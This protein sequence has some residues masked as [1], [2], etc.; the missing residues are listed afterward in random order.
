MKIKLPFNY[1]LF[2]A[3]TLVGLS[4]CKESD[5]PESESSENDEI[6]LRGIVEMNVA[7]RANTSIYDIN[8]EFYPNSDF[9]IVVS[10]DNR[11]GEPVVKKSRYVIPSG[12]KG[13]LMPKSGNPAISWISR[14]SEHDIWSW[15]VPWEP[16]APITGGSFPIEFRSTDIREAIYTSSNMQF[17]EG[18]FANGKLM[19]QC[20][21]AVLGGKRYVDQGQFVQL[22]FRHLCSLILLGE[23]V[24]VDNSTQT[25]SSTLRG[26][27]TIYGLPQR[28]TFHTTP[29][30]PEGKAMQPYIEMPE[31]FDY[32]PASQVT[33]AITNSS[34]SFKND[35]GFNVYNS[36]KSSST[37]FYDEWYIC[38]EVDLSRLS[39]IIEIFEYNSTT[40]EWQMSQKYGENGAFY[41]DFSSIQISRTPGSNYDADD[42]TDDSTVLHA[43]EFIQLAFNLSTKGNPS[44]RGVIVDWANT[45]SD[46]G[47]SKY[48]EDGIYSIVEAQDFSNMM[49]SGDPDKI[50]E[51]FGAYGSGERTGDD[52]D[53]PNYEDDLGIFRLYEDI[54]YFGTGQATTTGSTAKMSNLY[55]GDD[56][57]LDG[58]GHMVNCSTSSMKIGHVR[59]IYFRFYI[60]SY[61]TSTGAYSYTENI[62]YI[63]KSGQIY[64]VNPATY[65]MTDTGRNLNDYDKNPLT[66][67]LS[68]GTVS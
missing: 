19:R 16:E 61:S 40:K 15:T 38:P 60:S 26:N 48:D 13:I 29:F 1:I 66:L 63:D 35:S 23:F 41:G 46:R 24:I 56:Y 36:F 11:E 53:D 42:G 54:G 67:S 34:R 49:N 17:I 52:P 25:S 43:G 22:Q 28:A 5:M 57:I 50:D 30:T 39:F 58:M 51:Y 32:S 14:Y 21:G 65:E 4:A 18:S 10:G 44:I 3:F 37:S 59:D 12:A 55:V 6:L 20:V 7:T 8:A 33:F 47:A 31:D 64:K 62:I 2:I 27:M 9:N 45:T 68:S